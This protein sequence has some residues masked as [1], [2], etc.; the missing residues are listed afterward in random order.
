MIRCLLSAA[1][2]LASLAT[3]APAI[4]QQ[5]TVFAA[6]S[7]KE[8]LDDAARGFERSNGVTVSASYAASSALA[9]QIGGPQAW[10]SHLTK[11]NGSE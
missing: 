8:A 7:L 2:L 3:A 6:A 11:L 10:L 4:A 9:K 1:A 5:L